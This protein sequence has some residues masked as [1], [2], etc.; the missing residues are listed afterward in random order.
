VMSTITSTTTTSSLSIT[1]TGATQTATIYSTSSVI[2]TQTQS[3]LLTEPSTQSTTET[4]VTTAVADPGLELGLGVVIV[5]SVMM[6]MVNMVR[7][8]HGGGSIL[9]TRCGV[10]NSVGTKFCVGCGESLKRP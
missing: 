9:C 6:I 10:K 1:Q 5:F 2:T 7:R 3:N 8:S 4:S